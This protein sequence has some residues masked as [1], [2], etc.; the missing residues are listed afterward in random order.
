[1]PTSHY[2]ST[3][4]NTIAVAAQTL[5]LLNLLLIPGLAFVLLLV[6]FWQ[7]RQRA[8]DFNLS[9][10]QQTVN[11]SLWAG[12]LIVIVNA[13]ILLL[14]GYQ[15]AAVWVVVILYFTTVHATLIFLGVI[16]LVKAL[17]GQYWRYPLIGRR[18]PDGYRDD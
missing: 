11:A 3:R 14:G 17:A 6:L 18:L 4:P 10:L 15:S 8:D 5:Y 9:H 2:E 12:F 13:L 16:G 1:M 7:Q